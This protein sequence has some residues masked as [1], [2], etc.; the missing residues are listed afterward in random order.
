MSS[1]FARF[2][3]LIRFAPLPLPVAAD[4]CDANRPHTLNVGASP[5]QK[6]SRI[7]QSEPPPSGHKRGSSPPNCCAIHP[8]RRNSCVFHLAEIVTGCEQETYDFDR[9]APFGKAQYVRILHSAFGA[10]LPGELLR[11]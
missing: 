6:Q 9:F 4:D 3:L 10:F 7:A 11:E 5:T 1:R 2:F 8:E